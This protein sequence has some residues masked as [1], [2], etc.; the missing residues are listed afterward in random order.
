[1]KKV[2]IIL[3]CAVLAALV[4][5]GALAEG[6]LT[7][8]L[9]GSAIKVTWSVDC[10]GEAVLTVYQNDWWAE[11][12]WRTLYTIVVG[13]DFTQ[14]MA[15]E[16]DAVSSIN[17]TVYP[18]PAQDFVKIS[19]VGSQP[20]VVKVYNCLG[21]LVEEIEMISE[22]IEI[23]VSDYNPGVYFFNVNGETFRIIRN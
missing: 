14:P 22:E 10:G 8:R 11:A 1:M 17:A 23:N 13:R 21:M 7:G 6:K 4:L 2:C 15:V 3:I 20:S 18:N 5:T 19:A 16:E 12:F 9:N